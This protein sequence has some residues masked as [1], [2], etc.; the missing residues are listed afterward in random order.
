MGYE[1]PRGNF[2]FCAGL[3]P[4][5]RSRCRGK[6]SIRSCSSDAGMREIISALRLFRKK[7][8]TRKCRQPVDPRRRRSSG[9]LSPPLGRQ[10]EQRDRQ[11]AANP[12][13]YGGE[14]D[15]GPVGRVADDGEGRQ[16]IPR[17]AP[18]GRGEA[19]PGGDIGHE[20]HIDRVGQRRRN[21][22]ARGD[23]RVEVRQNH[24]APPFTWFASDS[25]RPGRMGDLESRNHW[26]TLIATD[27]A[28]P[29]Q[30]LA[31]RA[32]RRREWRKWAGKPALPLRPVSALS[33]LSY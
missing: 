24:G 26:W 10:A 20:H 12:R 17:A 27:Q 15:I 5:T 13:S 30:R 31:A 8:H 29:I 7:M 4:E 32:D 18:R 22:D 11:E 16:Q 28:P 23:Q 19:A 9:S 21:D 14:Q 2:Y 25:W 3:S 33:G 6:H 1:R